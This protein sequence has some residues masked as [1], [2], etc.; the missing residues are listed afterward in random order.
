MDHIFEDRDKEK[1][2]HTILEMPSKQMPG[3]YLPMWLPQDMWGRNVKAIFLAIFT[4]I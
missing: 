3:E 4:L 2:R 1:R